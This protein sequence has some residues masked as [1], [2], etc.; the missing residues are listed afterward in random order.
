MIADEMMMEESPRST[1]S[2]Y[3][4][5]GPNLL[6]LLYHIGVHLDEYEDQC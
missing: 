4:E 5:E 2:F 3:S 6:H 1:S